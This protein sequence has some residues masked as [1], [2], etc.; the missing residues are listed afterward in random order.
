MSERKPFDWQVWFYIGA[1]LVVPVVLFF[2]LNRQPTPK[3]LPILGPKTNDAQGNA[4][5]HHV[6][7][8]DLINQ[9]GERVTLADV[10]GKVAV[11]GFFFA[12]CGTICPKMTASLT[13]V[14]QKF[15]DEEVV[16]LYH[17]VD[18]V[19]DSVSV[20]AAYGRL[21]GVK[22]SNWHL[23]TG[24]KEQIYRLAR[25]SYFITATEGDGG[26]SDFIHD[27]NFALVDREGRIR[28]YYRGTDSADVDR[29]IEDI[30][31]L[32]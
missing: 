14:Q 30:E 27:E 1:V 17:T 24:D 13:R 10:R 9:N 26:P 20:L 8:F 4:V 19:H 25:K 5:V 18:P 28:G 23:L 7:D 31:K 32:K 6:L 21:R 11:A 22:P 12:S 2:I 16:I 29:L 3:D 15:P